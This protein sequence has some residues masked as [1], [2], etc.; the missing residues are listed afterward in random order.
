MAAQCRTPISSRTETSPGNGPGGDATGVGTDQQGLGTA[1]QYFWPCCGGNYTDFFQY[2]GPGLS[3]T[4]LSL[5]GQ[6]GGG[7]V[8]R[9]F[10]LLQQAGGLPTPD[11]QWPYTG[12]AN[13][14]VDPVN[15]ANV[16]ISSSVGRIFSTPNSGVT[17]F[18][19]G[20][21]GVFGT[22][23]SFSFAL[24]YGAPDPSAPD[25]VGNLGNFIYVGTQTG[26]IYVTQNGGGSGT[27]NN[28]INISAGLDGSPVESI[29]TDPIRGS[30]DAY[31]VTTSGVFYMADS[32]PSATNTPTWV[33]I[34]EQHPQPGI[35]HLRPALRPDERWQ[36]CQA[37]AGAFAF[38]D[39]GGL[40]LPDPVRSD[41][42]HQG[43]SPGVVRRF[44]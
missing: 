35:L 11:P 10:G 39:R 20:D 30:H 38:V 4:G 22:P 44:G 36:L 33:N 26:Q 3:G 9:T 21:P 16:V 28:W 34:T 14:A 24:A 32:I 37:Q 25:G 15:S 41:R 29:T 27:A 23:N 8:G 31:A 7:Y 1:Y 18:D 6:A 42:S 2:I 5:S 40:A 17:W 43:L 13:F 19:I 12:G